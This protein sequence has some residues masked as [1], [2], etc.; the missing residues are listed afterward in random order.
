MT[1]PSTRPSHRTAGFTLVELVM[2]MVLVGALATFAM[3]RLVD[4]T[5][6]RLRAFADELTAQSMAMQRLALAQRRPVVGTVTDTGVTFAYVGGATLASL[7]CPAAASPCIAEAGPRSV[8]FNAGN[9]GSATTSTGAALPVT[10]TGTGTTLK[11]QI[12]VETGLFRALP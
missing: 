8:T 4:L 1:T 3:P 11:F 12:E 10:V 6:F 7:G 9:S 5:S 2:V